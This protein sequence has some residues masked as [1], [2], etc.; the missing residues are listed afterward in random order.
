[1]DAGNDIAGVEAVEVREMAMS[2][3]LDVE[4]QFPFCGG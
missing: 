4:V 3:V 2:V 1:V